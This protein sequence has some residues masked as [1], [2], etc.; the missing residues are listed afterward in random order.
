M[1]EIYL[2]HIRFLYQFHLPVTEG[3]R[4]TIV[5]HSNLSLELFPHWQELFSPEYI[6]VQGQLPR[7]VRSR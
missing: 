3:F 2:N 6:A 5:I 7:L 1:T 4:Q